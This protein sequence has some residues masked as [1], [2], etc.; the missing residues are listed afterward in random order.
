M[1]PHALRYTKVK[2]ERRFRV[3]R[4]TFNRV[5]EKVSTR[6]KFKRKK[7]ALEKQGIHP[8]QRIVLALHVLGYNVVDS[9]MDEVVHVSEL[10]M[11]ATVVPFCEAVVE[12]FGPEYLVPAQ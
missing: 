4:H 10:G 3:P 5:Y 12:E 8:L 1:G 7:D 2:S 6:D 11:R 9:S